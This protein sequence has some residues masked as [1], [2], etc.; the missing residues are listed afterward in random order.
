MGGAWR[1]N[2]PGEGVE[3]C[4]H[5]QLTAA[6]ETAAISNSR[7]ESSGPMEFNVSHVKCTSLH[8]VGNAKHT[9]EAS[10]SI[11]PNECHVTCQNRRF[12]KQP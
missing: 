9:K 1:C 8:F 7:D 2:T 3:G 5:S 4:A 6:C 10:N 12:C 11:V